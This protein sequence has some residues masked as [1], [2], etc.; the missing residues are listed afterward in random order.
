MKIFDKFIN[1]IAY[2]VPNEYNF[3]LPS[4]E[5]VDTITNSEE[6]TESAKSPILTKQNIPD[7]V[8]PSLDVNLEFIKNKYN[9]DINSDIKIREFAINVKGK[10]YSAFL[11]YIEGMIDSNSINKFVIEPLILL[12]LL[13]L[14]M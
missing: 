2:K 5:D 7:N 12:V 10:Q 13:L 1:L 8:F 6:D 11:L 3:V 4:S 14:I 9:A